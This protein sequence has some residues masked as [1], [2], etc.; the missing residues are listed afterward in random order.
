MQAT[1]P[2]NPPS[3]WERIRMVR[4][5]RVARKCSARGNSRDGPS[6]VSWPSC[7]LDLVLGFLSLGPA[8]GPRLVGHGVTDIVSVETVSVTPWQMNPR[9]AAGPKERKPRKRS[10]KQ[11]CSKSQG[12]LLRECQP[13]SWVA[14]ARVWCRACL[15]VYYSHHTDK[16]PKSLRTRVNCMGLELVWIFAGFFGFWFVMLPHR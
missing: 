8:A 10:K 12:V 1:I 14:F 15:F 3:C 2:L 7:F 13:R 5:N 9:P 6:W 4:S 16:P 11:K